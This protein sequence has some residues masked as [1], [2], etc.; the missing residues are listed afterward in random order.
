MV[1]KIISSEWLITVETNASLQVE[2]CSTM[3]C[4]VCITVSL[5]GVGHEQKEKVLFIK[6]NVG[7]YGR[8]L[9]RIRK[10]GIIHDLATCQFCV[11][12]ACLMHAGAP[13]S[14]TVICNLY[15]VLYKDWDPCFVTNIR[16]LFCGN[17][18]IH[19]LLKWL[20]QMWGD[21]RITIWS[22]SET[23]CVL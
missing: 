11:L 20:I 9:T 10:I 23:F 6:K 13:A 8:P 2:K 5:W 7:N 17:P 4:M 3:M 15:L 14:F 22:V 1:Y 16:L 21:C 19:V 18:N 12:P